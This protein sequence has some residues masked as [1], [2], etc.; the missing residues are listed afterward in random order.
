MPPGVAPLNSRRTDRLFE[1]KRPGITTVSFGI[2]GFAY[3]TSR[4]RHEYASHLPFFYCCGYRIA[5]L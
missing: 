3:P 5:V 1:A 4:P 2:A